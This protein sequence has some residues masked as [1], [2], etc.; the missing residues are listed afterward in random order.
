[1]SVDGNRKWTRDEMPVPFISKVGSAG[2]E[3]ATSWSFDHAAT[4]RD[5]GTLTLLFTNASPKLTLKSIWRARRGRGPIEHWIEIEN[6]SPQRI[7]LAQQD[8]LALCGLH[9]EEPASLWWIKRGGSNATSQGGTYNE[10][11]T[12]H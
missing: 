3:L 5:R 1:A 6:Q 2:K 11:L 4:D 10:P 9:V 12:P 7:T 8:S